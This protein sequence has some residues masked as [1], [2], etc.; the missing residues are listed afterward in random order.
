MAKPVLPVFGWPKK[1]FHRALLARVFLN[2]CLLLFH[3]PLWVPSPLPETVDLTNSESDSEEVVL[4]RRPSP[5]ILCRLPP[6]P[7]PTPLPAPSNQGTTNKADEEQLAKGLCGHGEKWLKESIVYLQSSTKIRRR[8]NSTARSI[9]ENRTYL[10]RGNLQLGGGL[11][12]WQS[13]TR[14]WEKRSLS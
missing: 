9:R 12:A 6:L 13:R 7:L 4:S 8:S 1:S 2:G 11:Q 10:R 5:G 14:S 3:L